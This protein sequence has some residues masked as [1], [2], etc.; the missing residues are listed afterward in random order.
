VKLAIAVWGIFALATVVLFM[1]PAKAELME[2]QK[3]TIADAAKATFQ[4]RL[5]G[6]GM[7]SGSFIES[8]KEQ[9][10]FLTASHCGRRPGAYSITIGKKGEEGYKHLS[11][12]KMRDHIGADVMLFR[13]FNPNS[14]VFPTVKL[15]TITQRNSLKFGSKLIAMGYPLN[16]GINMFKGEYM[17]VRGGKIPAM[18]KQLFMKTTVPSAP[19]GSGG[20]L[21]M[22]TAEGLRVVGVTSHGFR[23]TLM[24]YYASHKSIND[25]IRGLMDAI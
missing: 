1:L 2:P 20:P 17:S 9:D 19:G 12:T 3:F 11:L 7:C 25:L 5:D 6:K 21:F 23:G 24:G 15:A 22:E 13:T 4:L 16:D 14:H 10:I 8:S 18:R